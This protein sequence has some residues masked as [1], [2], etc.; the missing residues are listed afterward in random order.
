MDAKRL[1]ARLPIEGLGKPLYV[2]SSI[3]STNDEAKRLADQG[4]PH[5][6]MVVAD[7]QSSGRG[8]LKRSWSTPERSALAMTLIVRPS[9]MSSAMST[10][11]VLGAL[12]VTESLIKRD[13][14]AWIK[15]PNDVIVK[16]GKLAG[17]LVEASWMGSELEYVVLGIGVN[18]RPQSIPKSGLEYPASCVDHAV[19][20]KVDRYELLFDIIH[21][22][23][24]WYRAAGTT[25]LLDTWEGYL[26]YR[27]NQVLL[28]SDETELTGKLEGLAQDGRLRLQLESG[29][30]IFVGVGDL[31]LRPID[32][33]MD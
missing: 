7:A 29:E 11:T 28:R 33:N 26:A 5:G 16:T 8:R 3:G 12:A 25:A 14:E 6:T 27:H 31:S 9:S 2:F 21:N 32:S 1:E 23:G 18:V 10:L 22:L 24:N 15:W 13:V 17:V 4:S 20:K 19:G 30:I